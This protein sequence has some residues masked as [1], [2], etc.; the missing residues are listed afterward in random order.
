LGRPGWRL[1]AGN[2]FVAP[3]GAVRVGQNC[4]AD[5][6]R[7]RYPSHLFRFS[8][9]LCNALAEAFPDVRRLARQPL[10]IAGIL[11]GVQ[12]LQGLSAAQRLHLAQFCS[13]VFVPARQ[14]I[15][16]QGQPGYGLVIVRQGQAM[17]SSVDERGRP[18]PT[19]MLHASAVYGETSLFEGG[20]HEA[21]VRAVSIGPTA[22]HDRLEGTDIIVLDRRD[23]EVA[24]QEEPQLWADQTAFRRHVTRRTQETRPFSWM[25]EGEKLIMKSRPHW[26]W[27]AGPEA[28]VGLAF[29][30]LWAITALAPPELRDEL[31][32][33]SLLV[34]ALILLPVAI[35]TLL[36]YLD[37]YYV[38]TDR[39]V[40]RRDRLLV[41]YE[42]RAETPLDQ[43]QDV[44]YDADFWGRLFNYGDV[45]IRSAARGEPI[46]FAHVPQPEKVQT[47]IKQ[48]KAETTAGSRGLRQEELR[49]AVMTDLRLTLPIPP[50]GRALG[51]DT[52]APIRPARWPWSRRQPPVRKLPAMKGTLPGPFVRLANRLPD[53][54]RRLLIGGPVQ[55]MQIQEGEFIWRKHPIQLIIQAGRPAVLL[56]IWL[57]F[58]YILFRTELGV[59]RTALHLPWWFIFVFF[60]GWVIWEIADYGNDLYILKED[61]IIDIEATPLWLSISR[62]ESSLDRVQNVRARQTGFWQ[63]ILG[64][65]DVEI[66]TAALDEGFTFKNV[67]NPQLVQALIFQK[68]DAFKARQAERQRRDRQQDI[69]EGIRIYHELHDE[70]SPW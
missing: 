22:D 56:L 58:G 67:A 55:E 28:A 23:M 16:T 68:L 27:L 59:G 39:R 3:G 36:N 64:Y 7:T 48:R 8:A 10:D 52:Q 2:F 63:N 60:A 14:N 47:L 33:F 69:I 46:K 29:L 41:F 34:S 40:T 25:E 1:T 26:L 61:R 53:P 57:A 51:A 21:T 13:W 30:G 11:A 4:V 37:D 44:T 17:R 49:K 43:I 12:M 18:R 24:F 45:T 15:T 70:D 6:A 54:W 38:I 19:D 9:E 5:S 32:I 50:V 65:G 35:F 42:A 20:E 62:R 31:A 66:Q